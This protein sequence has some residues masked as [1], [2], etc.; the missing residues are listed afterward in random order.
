MGVYIDFLLLLKRSESR[1]TFLNN[2]QEEI[3]TDNDDR[4]RESS[5]DVEDSFHIYYHMPFFFLSALGL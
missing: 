4:K 5:D 1:K 2:V 3:P